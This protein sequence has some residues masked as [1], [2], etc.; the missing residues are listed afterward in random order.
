MAIGSSVPV[1]VALSPSDA[2]AVP[3]L[4]QEITQGV[5]KWQSLQKSGGDSLQIDEARHELLI[6]TRSMM[7]ALETPRETMIKHCWAQVRTLS[8][9][10]RILFEC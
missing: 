7:Q 5:D 1:S 10:E 9:F 6:K 4:L 2:D 3:Q 8:I